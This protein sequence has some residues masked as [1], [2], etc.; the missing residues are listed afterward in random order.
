MKKQVEIRDTRPRDAHSYGKCINR[1]KTKQKQGLL[2][3]MWCLSTADC[4]EKGIVLFH[5]HWWGIVQSPVVSSFSLKIST[6]MDMRM[7]KQHPKV[8][9]LTSTLIAGGWDWHSVTINQIKVDSLF[10]CF[11][12]WRENVKKMKIFNL[13][14]ALTVYYTLTAN[15][16]VK[17]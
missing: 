9:L 17:E 2:E 1:C 11:L 8:S 12:P 13:R 7:S 5:H 4:H 15:D 14:W 3:S 10:G 6:L 16:P